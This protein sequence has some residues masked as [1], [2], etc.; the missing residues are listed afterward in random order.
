MSIEKPTKKIQC[1]KSNN[2]LIN[3]INPII[4]QTQSCR[5]PIHND[6]I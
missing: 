3:D 4:L 6:Q 1:I 5:I 2:S